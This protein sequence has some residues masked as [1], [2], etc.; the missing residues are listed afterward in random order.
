[1]IQHS[2]NIYLLYNIQI[3]MNGI[4]LWIFF[5]FHNLIDVLSDS[6]SY[7]LISHSIIMTRNPAALTRGVSICYQEA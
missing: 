2:L 6:F 1:M 7:E 3:I 4:M 5:F